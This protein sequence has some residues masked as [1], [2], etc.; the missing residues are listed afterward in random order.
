MQNKPNLKIDPM[1]VTQVLTAG[2]DKKTLGVRG[3]NK[4]NHKKA[5]NERNF[6][7]NKELRRYS[8]IHP[9]KNKPKTNP[10]KPNYSDL[11]RIKAIEM[12]IETRIFGV[13]MGRLFP[14]RGI[15]FIPG[16]PAWH[17]LGHIITPFR[18]GLGISVKRLYFWEKM[19][20]IPAGNGK[21]GR[22]RVEMWFFER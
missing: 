18:G 19:C 12:F 11:Y 8:P 6:C 3:K 22:E 13:I 1:A 7:Y 14:I 9:Q 21:V 20:Y 2:Y 17:A 15:E 10:N 16:A 5:E 4:P